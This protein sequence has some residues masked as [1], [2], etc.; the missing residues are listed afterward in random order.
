ME[1][2][3]SLNRPKGGILEYDV[4]PGIILLSGHVSLMLQLRIV[5]MLG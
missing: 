3:H 5:S 1:L 4:L 2:G